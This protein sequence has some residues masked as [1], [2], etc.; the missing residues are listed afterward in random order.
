MLA[1]V[2][3]IEHHMRSGLNRARH[4]HNHINGPTGCQNRRVLGQDSPTAGDLSFGFADG[5]YA[6][7]LGDVGL[8]K[9]PFRMR[10]SPICHRYETNSR[11]GCTKLKGDGT[12]RCARS[13]HPNMDRP[14]VRFTLLQ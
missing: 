9:R 5:A 4:F 3:R 6:A 11:H 12:A 14:S 13:N 1:V 10:L 8:P 2:K 7:P